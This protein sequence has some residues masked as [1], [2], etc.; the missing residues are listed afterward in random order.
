MKV[1]G[2]TDERC[3]CDCC[4]RTNLKCTV[5]ID[6]CD[7]DG[8]A[9]GEVVYY[10]RDCAAKAIHGN[11]RR[12]SVAKI[13]SLAGAIAYCSKWLRSTEKHTAKIVLAAAWVRFGF[14][15][16]ADGPFSIVFPNGVRVAR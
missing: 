4:G 3:E 5:A 15:G 10:G 13:E 16:R 6:L 11:N 1:L 12:E 2:I 9:S 8:N 7:A 14:V